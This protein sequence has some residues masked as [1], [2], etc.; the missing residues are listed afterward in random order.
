MENYINIHMASTIC[1]GVLGAKIIWFITMNAI[2]FIIPM[3]QAAAYRK[4]GERI[5]K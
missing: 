3:V 1:L 2:S 4:G 5:G